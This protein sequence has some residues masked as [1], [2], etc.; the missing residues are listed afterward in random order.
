MTKITKAAFMAKIGILDVMPKVDVN[1]LRDRFHV[2]Y[3]ELRNRCVVGRTI[4]DSWGIKPTV[5]FA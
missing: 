3:W 4:S 2:S 5:Y 1:T